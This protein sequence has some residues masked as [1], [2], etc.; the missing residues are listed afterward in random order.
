MFKKIVSSSA[1]V[2]VLLTPVFSQADDKYRCSGRFNTDS[3]YL[4]EYVIDDRSDHEVLKWN[5]AQFSMQKNQVWYYAKYIGKTRTDVIYIDKDTLE[6]MFYS[7]LP[8]LILYA[9]G[10]CKKV[11]ERYLEYTKRYLTLGESQKER[12]D[13]HKREPVVEP[14]KPPS[15][16]MPALP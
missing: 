10:T 9:N 2:L 5:G 16:L 13:S 4:H 12:D 6:V 3:D 1:V 7:I 14:I 8:G 15:R 11:P